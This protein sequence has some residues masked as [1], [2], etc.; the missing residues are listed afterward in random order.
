VKKNYEY[1]NHNFIL[2]CQRYQKIEELT[3]EIVSEENKCT[4]INKVFYIY[5]FITYTFMEQYI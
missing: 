3:T 5:I 1:S 4:L 2:L